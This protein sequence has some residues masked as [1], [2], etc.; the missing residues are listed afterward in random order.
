MIFF[1]IYSILFKTMLY[2]NL[3]FWCFYALLILQNFAR[4]Y[5]TKVLSVNNPAKV[6]DFLSNLIEELNRSL[7]F[8]K[9]IYSKQF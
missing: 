8:L 5:A 9:K 2:N 6:D 1:S 4:V 3:I 7:E